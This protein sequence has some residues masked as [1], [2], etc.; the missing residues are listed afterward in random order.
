M[1]RRRRFSLKFRLT[2]SLFVVS[3]ISIAS[4][5]YFAYREAYNTDEPIAERTLQGQAN[6]L[7]DSMSVDPATGAT[8]IQL[9]DDWA[10]AYGTPDSGFSYTLYDANGK[11]EAIAPNLKQPLEPSIVASRA[12]YGPLEFR[13]PEA[14]MVMTARAPRG[15]V[16]VVSRGQVD[17]EALAESMLEESVEP[18]FLLIPSGIVALITIWLVGSWSLRPLERASREA[19]EVGPAN[20]TARV[21]ADGLPDEVLPLVA[22]VNG[23]MDRLSQAYEAERRLTADAAHELRTPL[24]VLDLRLQRAQLG[25]GTDWTAIRRDF[26]HL[27]R[28]VAQ[29][30]DLARME[31]AAYALPD[32]QP[33]NLPRIVRE[34]TAMVLPLADDAGREIEVAT[35]A[36]LPISIM[37]YAADLR[38]MVRNL[39]DNALSH[40]KGKITVRLTAPVQADGG[41]PVI[42]QVSDEGS[43]VPEDLRDSV[44]DRFRKGKASS[45]GSGLGLA[46]VR[47][48]ARVHGG[49]ARV[50]PTERNCIEVVLSGAARRAS[51]QVA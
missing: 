46:I 35:D 38:N 5:V 47:H 26:E 6:E 8:R 50:H 42:L 32:P 25:G 45:P 3:A 40:G 43:G 27:H 20:P 19:A 29:L 4:A 34:A 44:F 23:A 49:F 9:P 48:V 15:G 51:G 10:E 31:S 14:Q 41:E 33:V 30:L 12:E 39:L 28:V 13:G 16:L 24:A 22:A 37:G 17:S 18:M 36:D 1:T 2:A 21:S 11:V 7:L